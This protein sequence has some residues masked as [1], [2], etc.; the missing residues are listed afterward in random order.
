MREYED[1]AARSETPS[2]LIPVG[3]LHPAWQEFT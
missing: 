1:D 3:I 2:S